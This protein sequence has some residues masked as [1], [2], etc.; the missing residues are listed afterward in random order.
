MLFLASRVLNYDLNDEARL[1]LLASLQEREMVPLIRSTRLSCYELALAGLDRAV[2]MERLV[3]ASTNMDEQTS[4]IRGDIFCFDDHVFFLVFGEPECGETG[5][6]AGIIYERRTTEPLRKLDSFC[7]TVSLCL[8]DG[9]NEVNKSRED[10]MMDLAAWRQDISDVHRGFMRFVAKQDVDSLY[11][12]VRKEATVERVQAAEMLDDNYTRNF[13]HGIK[14]ALGEGYAVGL[15]ATGMNAPPDFSVNRLVEVGLLR[16]EVVISCRQTDHMLFSLP[17]PDALAAITISE[18]RCSECGARIVDEKIEEVAAPTPL[19]SAMLEDG[20]W[21]VNRVYAILRRLGV[22]ES[23]I[24]VEP[25]TGEGEARMMVNVCDEPFLLVLRDGDLTPAFAR[26]AVDIKIGTESR[27]LVVVVTGTIHK[28]GRRYLLN[29]AKRVTRGGNDFELIIAEGVGPATSEL[30]QA[31]KRVS[32]KALAEQL[33]VL[34]DSLGANVAHLLTAR[35]QLLQTARDAA[36][37][38]GLYK[39]AAASPV[40]SLQSRE[41]NIPLIDLA[42][43]EVGEKNKTGAETG[44]ARDLDWRTG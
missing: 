1:H 15:S 32:R 13:I 22:P 4:Y 23:E 30:E 19:A 35:F 31:F 44:E 33:C 37:T 38:A 9:E 26:R 6:R 24:A 17:S 34:D 16:R 43:I 36:P 21:L 8:T 28:E 3:A 42:H 7:Q 11:T 12:F 25:P 20:A 39:T 2:E 41:R 40:T 5:T 10:E 29:F 18:A 14:E 27:H